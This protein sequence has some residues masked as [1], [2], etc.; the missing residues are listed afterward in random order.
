M[1]ELKALSPDSLPTALEK[2]HRYRLLNEPME[3]ESICRDI[4][5]V[6]ADHQEA[7]V[8]LL[9]ALTDQFEERLY[10]C[11][12]QAQEVLASQPHLPSGYRLRTP[13]QGAAQARR[14]ALRLGRL[15]LVPPGPGEL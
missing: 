9:L 7:L 1:F 4:L 14:P 5:A 3:A 10:P 15:W 13:G 11:F 6:A 8:T 2:A 12:D